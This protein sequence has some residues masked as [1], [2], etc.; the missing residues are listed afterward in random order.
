MGGV[1]TAN[2]DVLTQFKQNQQVQMQEFT[3]FVQ[4]GF[5][6]RLFMLGKLPM[7]V[8]AGLRVKKITAESC[9]VTVPYRWMNTNPF[10]STYFAVLSMAAEMSTGLMSLMATYKSSPSVS[11]LVT[12]IEADFTKKATGLTTFTCNDGDKIFKAVDDAVITGEGINIQTECIGRN[13]AGE[14]ECRFRVTWSFK[15]RAK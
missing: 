13:K 15:M 8:V 3:K 7:G 14:E 10:Q 4:N 6:F 11:M 2:A 12:H 9:E 1:L 5:L